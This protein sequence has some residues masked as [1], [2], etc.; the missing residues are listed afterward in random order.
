MA[1][2]TMQEA[3]DAAQGR[4]WLATLHNLTADVPGARVLWSLSFGDR[5]GLLSVPPRRPPDL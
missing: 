1:A 2:T 4:R 3:E 5:P